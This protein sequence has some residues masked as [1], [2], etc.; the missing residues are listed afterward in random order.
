MRKVSRLLVAFLLVL[1]LM[2][3]N[4]PAL[5]TAA[6]ADAPVSAGLQS[7]SY[8]LVANFTPERAYNN[9]FSDIRST[10]WYYEPIKLSYELGLL[11]GLSRT[12]FGPNQ[13]V[14][15]AQ[16]ASIASKLHSIY[17]TGEADF[18][19]GNPWYQVFLDYAHSN[20]FAVRL[21]SGMSSYDRPASRKEVAEVL[22]K[23]LPAYVISPINVIEAGTIPDVGMN[24]PN[25]N[26]IYA[27]YRAGILTGKDRAGSFH[28]D[29]AI[30]R[31]ELAAI[32]ARMVNPSTRGLQTLINRNAATYTAVQ[33]AARCAPAVFS[34]KVYVRLTGYYADY[35]SSLTGEEYD[36]ALESIGRESAGYGI[37]VIDGTAYEY[38]IASGI[39]LTSDGL[40][41]TN[42]HVI[43]DVHHAIAITTDGREHQLEGVFSVDKDN[44][45][46]II[47]V[48][49]SGFRTLEL[50][51]SGRLRQGEDIYAI[52]SPLGLANTFTSGVVSNVNRVLDGQTLI[53]FSAPITFGSSGG[54]LINSKGQIVGITTSGYT[55]TGMNFA[56]PIRYAAG[57]DRT[58]LT[59][60]TLN[61]SAPIYPRCERIIDFGAYTGALLLDV[62]FNTEHGG[63]FVYEYDRRSF[64]NEEAF[65]RS[66]NAYVAAL[67]QNGMI[68]EEDEEIEGRVFLSPQGAGNIEALI[69]T[70]SDDKVT[71]I[72]WTEPEVYEEDERVL[73]LGWFLGIPL[74]NTEP[75]GN[76]TRYTYDAEEEYYYISN[77]MEVIEELYIPVLEEAGFTLRSQ[78]EYSA[79]DVAYGELYTLADSQGKTIEIRVYYDENNYWWLYISLTI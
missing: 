56:V 33:I 30:K 1:A 52:G 44:D 48:S 60:V 7:T 22:A 42:Y 10:D 45:L 38:G 26:A 57:M 20:G 64:V 34:L 40:A 23:T 21:P 70:V 6:G 55:G 28:P 65:G 25:A 54:A 59:P 41:V 16:L 27:L 11:D 69:L 53:Q 68:E 13:A 32:V 75:A 24:H 14:T 79:P 66:L 51:D 63:S 74:Y 5:H 17:N 76:R 2:G 36:E 78:T 43:Q 46:A 31:S 73:D 37:E 4:V 12:E 58:S 9:R 19:M 18:T 67:L 50:G 8:S 39:F 35:L 29:D 15:M 62:T 3:A 49:G 47:K 72:V 77:A 61:Q 71:V